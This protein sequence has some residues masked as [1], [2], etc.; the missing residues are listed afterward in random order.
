MA[1]LL[2]MIHYITDDEL[3]LTL[4]RLSRRLKE[5][6]RLIIRVA[7]PPQRDPSWVWRL[8]SVGH[9]L[10]RVPAYYRTVA[11]LTNMIAE[12]GFQVRQVMP[13]GDRGESMWFIADNGLGPALSI[14]KVVE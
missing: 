13:S 11:Q 1:L 14:N 6:G 7:V 5:N 4:N 2:D 10:F 8:A 9:R 12:S 3:R